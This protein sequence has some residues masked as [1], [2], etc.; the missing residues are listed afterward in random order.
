MTSASEPRTFAVR[1][2]Q[3]ARAAFAALAAV[4]I[5]FSPDHSAVVGV[6]VFSGFAIATALVLLAAVWLVYPATRRMPVILLGAVTL[7][8]G[9]AGG[10]APVRTVTGYFV[11]VIS[12]ALVSGAIEA[13]AGMRALR[14]PRELR[15][16]EV[17]PW[18]APGSTA[19][20]PA[21]R[22]EGRDALVIGILTIVLGIALLFVN[23]AFALQ[24]SIDDVP[25]T[26]TL[27]G[28]TIGV[29]IFG[30]YA[31]IV[32]V[33]LAIAGFSPLPADAAD[34]TPV[35][36]ANTAPDERGGTA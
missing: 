2:V 25:E 6:S 23:P 5:T 20:P 32:A 15:A 11:L 34:Q 10:L 14:G 9:M 30:G 16:G 28:I 22:S 19:L 1:H 3:L 13:V 29:G 26:F 8:A 12:W 33:Y 7:V 17:A 31:A 24:Y 36:S 35:A 4:M 18:S 21:P 27:T